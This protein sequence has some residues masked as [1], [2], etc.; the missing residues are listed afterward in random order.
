LATTPMPA[1][2][3]FDEKIA[4]LLSIRY[5]YM[6]VHCCSCLVQ[7]VATMPMPELNEKGSNW[8]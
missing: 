7:V 1:V 6:C 8:L 2:R 3:R 5:E 4:K